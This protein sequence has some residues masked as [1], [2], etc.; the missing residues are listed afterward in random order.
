MSKILQSL[1]TY[2]IAWTI[3][4]QDLKISFNRT[5]RMVLVCVNVMV[6]SVGLFTKNKYVQSRSM[7]DNN[8]P[9]PLRKIL[10]ENTNVTCI[11]MYYINVSDQTNGNLYVLK[12]AVM[13]MID[14]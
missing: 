4:V 6:Y 9:A 12:N 10:W 13:I 7:Y 3:D 2:N 5:P 8:A 1:S 14:Q 11:L